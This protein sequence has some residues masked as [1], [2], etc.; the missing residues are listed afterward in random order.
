MKQF[1][2]FTLATI[3]GIIITSLIGLMILFGIIGAAASSSDK[4]VKVKSD[5][6]Y[7]I[8]L[9]GQLVE[10]S[11]EDP[12]ADVFSSAFGQSV[13]SIGLDDLLANIKK[14]KEDDHIKGIYLNGGSLSGAYASIKEL[15]DALLDFKESGKFIVA[16][17]DTYT[18]KNYYLSSVA[19]KLMINTKGMIEFQGIASNTMFIKNTLDK[20][21]VEM[22]IVKVGTYK[23]AVEPYIETKMSDA[24]R[25]QVT[26]FTQS[27]WNNILAEISASRDIDVE[28]L[29][30]IADEMMT[31][32]AT[33]IYIENKLVDG[34]VY[35]DEMEEVLKE[36][37]E[38]EKYKDINFVSHK[39]M[40]N[41]KHTVKMQKERIAV[42]YAVG[43]IDTETTGSGGINSTKLVKTL[44]QVK[45]DKSI[46]AV[47]FRV[48]SPGGSAY[49]SEQIWRAVTQLKKEK[50]VIVSM[51]DYAASGGY[52]IS[53]EADSILAQPNTLTGSIG[54]FGTIPNIA[55]LNKKIGLNYDGVKT[56]KMSDAIDLNRAFTPDERNLMQAYV[57]EGYELFVKRCADGRDI[58]VDEL[59]KIAEGRVWTGEDAVELGLV[60]ALG[61]L[62]D[63][64][65][66]AAT[67]ANLDKYMVKSYPEKEDFMTKLLKDLNTDFEARW[68][69]KT[70][71]NEAYQVMMQIEAAKNMNG[72]YTLMPFNI[73]MN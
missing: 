61:G 58:E 43:G 69:K 10:R 14:A 34:L 64:I 1:L 46:K 18:Q 59:K 39:M 42:V 51:G 52:Y 37:V 28:T 16:Y 21:G 12:F 26:V 20:L 27:I 23:S 56:N 15:R 44:N 47:V 38:V 55:G 48:N 66:I 35:A 62:D 60:D 17:A 31:F 70:L 6:V 9:K 49:G 11:E 8:E 53:C 22:Q 4:A 50:P 41:V 2:K 73:T 3:V 36:L 54:I 24:N 25:E 45:D 13:A 7:E 68:M 63:A 65:K 29:N 57:N 33:E 32:Q 5:S 30:G 19:D 72:L 40:N 71:G 67:K